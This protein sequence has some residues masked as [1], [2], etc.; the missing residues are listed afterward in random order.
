M[1]TTRSRW[2][3]C[4]VAIDSVRTELNVGTTLVPYVGRPTIITSAHLSWSIGL[5]TFRR[6]LRSRIEPVSRM[7]VDRAQSVDVGLFTG[8]AT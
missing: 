7:V 2:F 3:W 6:S 5:D 8:Q 1:S 4:M